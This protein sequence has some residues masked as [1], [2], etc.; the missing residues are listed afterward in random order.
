M[1]R[2]LIQIGAFFITLFSFWK[3][4]EAKAKLKTA[5][6]NK[7]EALKLSKTYEKLNSDTFVDKPANRLCKKSD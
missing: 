2:L 5:N 7:D 1:K 6:K 4:G 3:W